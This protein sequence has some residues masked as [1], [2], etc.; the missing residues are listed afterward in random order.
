MNSLWDHDWSLYPCGYLSV[1]VRALKTFSF[2]H[3]SHTC[4]CVCLLTCVYLTSYRQWESTA[5]N[6]LSS[7]LWSHQT[8]DMHNELYSLFIFRISMNSG[9]II[10]TRSPSTFM[11]SNAI[12]KI[13]R[14]FFLQEDKS[15]VRLIKLPPTNALDQLTCQ[16]SLEL[17]NTV[18][19][20]FKNNM[21]QKDL[22]QS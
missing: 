1:Q 18:L 8:A 3:A 6:S 22:L 10:P 9:R 15:C 17:T 16:H 11:S 20:I 21:S 12:S 5:S 4:L 14:L 19:F 13:W 7:P 2:L